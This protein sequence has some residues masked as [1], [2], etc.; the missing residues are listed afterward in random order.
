M[1][2]L[3]TTE[4]TGTNIGYVDTNLYCSSSVKFDDTNFLFP[5]FEKCK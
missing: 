5:N 1:K 4:L 3:Q 2:D